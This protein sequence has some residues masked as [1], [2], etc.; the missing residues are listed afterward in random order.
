MNDTIK[1]INNFA[2]EFK[3]IK[4]DPDR[5]QKSQM[6]GNAYFLKDNNILVLPGGNGD[7]RYPYG[8]D[9]FNFWACATG[10]MN[11][12]EGLFSPFRRA[13]EEQEP[14]IAFFAGIPS[15]ESKFVPVPILSVPRIIDSSIPD[16]Q[17]YTVFTKSAAY[18]IAEFSG[19]RISVRVFPTEQ[20]DIKFTTIV[21]NLTDSS[22][23]L[24][25]SSYINPFM[26]N[27]IFRTD[28]D[29]WFKEIRVLA[30]INNNSL[31]SFLVKVNE[32]MDRH[33]SISHYGLIRRKISLGEK[34][35]LT[36]K[37]ETPSRYRYVGGSFSSLHTPTPFYEGS[38]NDAGKVCTFVESAIAG[39]ILHLE[40]ESGSNIR[41]DTIFLFN[42]DHDLI[43][44]QNNIEIDPILIDKKL[45]E[46]ENIDANR[47]Q[48]LKIK[49]DKIKS[50]DLKTNVFNAFIEHLKKQVEFCSLIKGYIQLSPNSL[51]GIRDVFQ[52][53]EGLAFYHPRQTKGKMLEALNY[54]A[55]DGRCFRQYSLPSSTGEIGRMD[56]RPFIDQGVWV[57]STIITY[58]RITGDLEFLKEN[59]G[60]H[61]IVNEASQK[62]KQSDKKDSVLDHLIKIFAYLLR[63]LDHEQTGCLRTMYGDWND[64][65]DGLGISKD[66]NTDYGTGV[67]VMATMQL[68]QNCSEMIELLEEVDREKF[69]SKI[70]ECRE[71]KA[72]LEKSLKEHALISNSKGEKRILHGWG[73]KKSYLVGSYEDP[74][75]ASR[76][77]L[78][79]PAFWVLSGLYETDTSLKEDILRSF[80]RLDSKYGLRTFDPAFSENTPWVGRIGK[81]PPGTAENGASYI[82]ATAF[83]IMALFKMGCPEK[84]WDQLI[85]ILP[86][87]D[88]HDNLSH[89][90]FVM[91]NSYGYNPEKGIDGQN[92]NDWQTGSSNVVLKVLIRFV[93]GFEPMLNGLWIQPAAW[94]PFD[95]YSF[96]SKFRNQTVKI[97][98][99]NKSSG[100][101]IFRVNGVKQK[102]VKDEFLGIDKLWIDAN[103]ECETISVEI[104][105]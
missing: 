18:Y 40:I 98:Y 36:A 35:K 68:Y 64:A 86:F 42:N 101:R 54:T 99:T 103:S 37:E 9:G 75:G 73:D 95:E 50:D 31:S 70:D 60:Y 45:N 52:A 1:K 90:P 10:Y 23:K 65:V 12:N 66:P 19:F 96:E 76:D 17:R 14:A 83:G 25:L 89:S 74:D 57:I 20:R 3:A 39:D 61:E 82:H 58:V 27:R 34:N 6:P 47:Q 49:V 15:E 26:R 63:H 7:S 28:E 32:D 92:M 22:K 67:S 81:L 29:R 88:I 97:Q 51:I 80:D 71:A 5:A 87:T 4:T 53:L 72:N 78:T 85:K 77:A 24:F 46:L 44:Q 100:S 84:A 2:E 48:S 93:F 79:A 38:F 33:H 16:V 13:A 94:A 62:V 104:I 41:T 55:P 21:Q 102:S 8:F 43:Q 105:D 11:C 56:L 59:C 30:P 69:K 91:P